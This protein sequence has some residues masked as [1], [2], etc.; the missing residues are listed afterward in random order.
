MAHDLRKLGFK[1]VF[2][3]KGGYQGWCD[4]KLPLEKKIVIEKDCITCHS[5]VTP[6]I[7]A[8]WKLSEHSKNEVTC[9][10][11]HGES[12]YTSEDVEKVVPVT[13]DKCTKCHD[14]QG[15]Q[16]KKGKHAMAWS[17]MK[18]FPTAHWQL[19][20]SVEG[21][22]G[23]GSCHRIG[24]KSKSEMKKLLKQGAGFGLASCDV[25]H[26][27]HTFFKKEAQQ[28]QA[29]QTCHSGIDYPQWQMYSGSKHGVRYSLKQMGILPES[30]SAPTCQDCH[31]ANG[32]HEVRAAWGFFGLRPDIAGD[33]EWE[34]AS[35]TIM[36]AL[37]FL[38]EKGQPTPKMDEAIKHGLF[39]KDS[40]EWG[41]ERVKMV[42]ACSRCHSVHFTESELKKGDRMIRQAD[43]LMAKAINCIAELYK[44]G[45]LKKPQAFKFP[46]PDFLQPC[47]AP[48]RIEQLLWRMFGQYR[49]RAFQGVFHQNSIYAFRHGLS[50]MERSLCEIQELAQGLRSKS[51]EKSH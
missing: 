42:E 35:I 34:D 22:E 26:T 15:K 21:S 25:C 13:P 49:M 10:V 38:D 4:A 31:M 32:N 37:G 23:C 7:V 17:T 12:H 9:G 1:K 5:K 29:C 51:R 28:P 24:L 18:V 11:C 47:E 36:R 19:M 40:I 30:V 44:D 46:F 20:A 50:E 27:R 48:R 6:D 43:I 45:I 16:F 8:E 14:T 39:R 41:S 33:K 3:L 2:A